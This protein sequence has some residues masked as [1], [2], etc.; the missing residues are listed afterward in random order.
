MPNMITNTKRSVRELNTPAVAMGQRRKD[1]EEMAELTL[2]SPAEE[3]QSIE[4]PT[5]AEPFYE[6]LEER[7]RPEWFV[8]VRL[9]DGHVRWFVRFTMTGLQVRRYGPFASKEQC[10]LFLNEALKRLMFDGETELEEAQ[11][12][13][14]IEDAFVPGRPVYPIVEQTLALHAKDL[15]QPK[16]GR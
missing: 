5:N 12:N 14:R 8:S 4:E 11:E 1:G 3:A 7:P 6:W 2:L 9:A 15:L 16:R 10:L 13:H